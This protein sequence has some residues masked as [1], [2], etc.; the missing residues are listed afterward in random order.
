[1]FGGEKQALAGD[2]HFVFVAQRADTEDE[3]RAVD[4][5]I[6]SAPGQ[7]DLSISPPQISF[8]Y[9]G[10]SHVTQLCDLAHRAIFQFGATPIDRSLRGKDDGHDWTRLHWLAAV[11]QLLA[12]GL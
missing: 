5:D 9:L 4:T 7:E 12:D 10:A 8:R 3:V 6:G 11:Q 1:L 2:R